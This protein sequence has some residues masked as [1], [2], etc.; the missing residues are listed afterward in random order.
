M[1]IFVSYTDLFGYFRTVLEHFEP[2]VHRGPCLTALSE[3][4]LK[5]L[6]Q[7]Q[8]Q[9]H[10]RFLRMREKRRS[11]RLSPSIGHGQ[12]I[13]ARDRFRNARAALPAIQMNFDRRPGYATF[14]PPKL[15]SLSKN[16]S[17]TLA[18][19]YD[20]KMH[21]SRRKP[22]MCEDGISRRTYAEFAEIESIEPGAGLVLAAEIHRYSQ[23]RPGKIQVHDHQ[24]NAGV[25]DYFV[26]AGLFELLS[27]D[28]HDIEPRGSPGSRKTLRYQS[29]LKSNGNDVKAL[30][31]RLQDLAGQPV[32]GRILVYNA[33]AEALKNVEHAYP[34]WFRSWPYTS[35]RRWWTSGFWD[36]SSK[37]VGLQLYD[38]GAGIPRTLPRQTQF[39]KLLKILDPER[40]D[41][42][43]IAAAME[44]GRT[45]TGQSGRGKGLAEMADWIES[46]GSGFLRILSGRGEV[47]Y[48]PGGAI[49]KR[50]Y[51]ATFDGTLVQWELS[52]A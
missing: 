19:I 33:I 31:Q 30:R 24:W 28:P 25:R 17:E 37:T 44:Y 39:R 23:T 36:P 34:R 15:F 50:E 4:S 20:F 2:L 18:F 52:L 45:S 1:A 47:T 40:N 38:Q 35:S 13:V 12:A 5:K 16:F 22:L 46:S 9:R 51:D 42:G 14:I 11:T 27:I 26:D 49:S 8:R 10:K 6:S 32:G 41:S 29:G 21:F 43:L 7:T 48:K 3:I